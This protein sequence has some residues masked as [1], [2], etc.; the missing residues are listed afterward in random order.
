MLYD[1]IHQV[2]VCVFDID[3]KVYYVTHVLRQVI[4]IKTRYIYIHI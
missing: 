2:R 3:I 1:E 4:N